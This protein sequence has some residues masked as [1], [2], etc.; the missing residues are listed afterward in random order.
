MLG[1]HLLRVAETKLLPARSEDR[2][3]AALSL[4]DLAPEFPLEETEH[5]SRTQRTKPV[6]MRRSIR[7]RL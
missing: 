4:A 1:L 2:G 7:L 5:R 6:E 3:L